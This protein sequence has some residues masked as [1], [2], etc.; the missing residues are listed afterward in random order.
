MRAP[1]SFQNLL[2][3]HETSA[4]QSMVAY[5]KNLRQMKACLLTHGY[6]M[7]YQ[8]GIRWYLF[9]IALKHFVQRDNRPGTFLWLPVNSVIFLHGMWYF[10][11]ILLFRP[12]HIHVLL[13]PIIIHCHDLCSTR[14][15]H[16]D[17]PHTTARVNILKYSYQVILQCT[18]YN[19]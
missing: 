10:L 14:I 13:Q 9:V 5:Y 2:H 12:L 6:V 19:H 3:K 8:L 7:W 16:F 11:N 15:R 18:T 17:V 4:F 1:S